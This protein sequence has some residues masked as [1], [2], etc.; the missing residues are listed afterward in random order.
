MKT[1]SYF[2]L[3]VAVSLPL[4][5]ACNIYSPL[6]SVSSDEDRIEEALVCLHAGDFEC[7]IA[8]YEALTPGE[9]RNR[10]LC[11]AHMARAGLTINSLI[12]LFE[13]KNAQ[14]VGALANA[15]G[16]W[17]SVKQ[18]ASESAVT[19]CADYAANTTNTDFAVLL[20]N[21][22]LVVSCATLMAKT[23]QFV[24]DASDDETCD[25]AGNNDGQITKE[26][27]GGNEAGLIVTTG[28]CPADV[29]ACRTSL[30]QADVAGLNTAKLDEIEGTLD[31]LPPELKPGGDP[32]T[33]AVRV[34]IKSTVA[35]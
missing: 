23:D 33:D 4:L 16:T 19:A 31:S 5:L 17:S 15:L 35:N 3:T 6:S 1:T 21:L 34:A 28:M 2:F 27:I 9:E 10:R 29:V 25:T 20:Q 7:A 32:L 12:N 11:T 30:T 26:D 13:D 14:V 22:S 24:A 8:N 18:A